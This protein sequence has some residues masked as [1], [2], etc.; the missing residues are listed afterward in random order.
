MLHSALV[1]KLKPPVTAIPT[2]KVKVAGGAYM[3]CDTMVP[4]MHWW[5][6]GHT[7]SH[8]MR[9]LPLGGYDGIL[10]MDWLEQQGLM[11]CN[12]EEKW[13]SFNHQNQQI[14]LQ[15][16]QATTVS[17]FKALSVEQLVKGFKGNDIWA[18][19]EL[20]LVENQLQVSAVIPEE[21]QSIL[22]EFAE[23]FQAPQGLPPHRE[24][25]HTVNLFP[26]TQPINCRSYR[27]SPFQKDEIEKQV[28][29]M[30]QQGTVISSVSPFASP[31]LLVKKKDGS[32]DFCIDYRKLNA[33]TVKSK[34]P[35]PVVDE[36]LDELAGTKIFSK[37]DLR[38]G[39]H[40]IRMVPSDEMKT[41]F[42]THN[43]HY[44][45]RVMPAFWTNQ[46][47]SHVSMCYEFSICT[48]CQE[49]C[50][51]FHGRHLGLQ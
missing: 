20:C 4:N 48:I 22:T 45:F 3:Y 31:V 50:I 8:D 35:L 21:I 51:G 24:F 36:L 19:A 38:A 27:Y 11:N 46:C 12:W 13:I 6:Q 49:I 47:S 2:L 40:Q 32:W 9:I 7:F 29:E 17:S 34:F 42:K 14:Q 1:H 25:D 33:V 28:K 5:L 37:L 10:G 18:V 15:G 26:D 16:I 41:A 39:Y 23:V 43:G 44:Q 30:L